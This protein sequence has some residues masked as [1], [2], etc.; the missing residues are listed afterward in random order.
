MP[1][2]RN[3]GIFCF[4]SLTL[5]LI[6]MAQEPESFILLA[7]DNRA[8]VYLVRKSFEEH[9]IV[10][11][12]RVVKDG[13]EAIRFLAGLGS[14]NSCP[15]LVVLDLNLPKITGQE[16]LECLRAH[17]NCGG[18][19]VIVMTSSDSPVDKSE[20]ARLGATAYFR[21]PTLLDEFMQLGALV[22]RVLEQSRL[23]R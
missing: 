13:E 2:S 1:E 16:I 18:V 5:E 11:D 21:K 12:L 22:K 10:Q 8:D 4:T 17:P 6:D 15:R 7:E 19:P 3:G 23:G 14:E 20:I 9:G